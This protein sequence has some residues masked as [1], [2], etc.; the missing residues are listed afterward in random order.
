MRKPGRLSS[1]RVPSRVGV[2]SDTHSPEFVNELPPRVFEA[3]SGVEL[4]LH[5]GDIDGQ[6]TLDALERIAPVIA[7]KG[8]HDQK[9]TSLPRSHEVTIAGKRVVVVHG[10]RSKW[11]EEPET[12]L[13]TVSLGYYHPH[14]GLARALRRRFPEADAIVYGHTHRPRV[15]VIDGVLL[16]NPGGVYQWT[17]D[18]V[19]KRLG[20]K[21]GW[22]EWSWLQVA[23]YIRSHPRP[24]V[25]LLE[26]DGQ[27]I[28]PTVIE[29]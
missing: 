24:S 12:F 29:L 15:E 14:G 26:I 6:S 16:F 18:T 5:A 11:I 22:F 13:W 17:P 4:I 20:E 27:G 19:R 25:G 8:D 1:T 3:L 2:L 23:R 21:V 28:V 10:D 9:L 7:V